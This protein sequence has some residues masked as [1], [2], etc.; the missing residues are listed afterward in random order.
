[1]NYYIYHNWQADGDKCTIHKADC[2]NCNS[3]L[4][5]QKNTEPGRNGVWIGPFSELIQAENYLSR[6]IINPKIKN[7]NCK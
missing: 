3:G 4:G 1:M 7:H 2:K 6:K 5:K